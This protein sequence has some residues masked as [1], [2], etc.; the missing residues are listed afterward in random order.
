MR[1]MWPGFNSQS[2]RTISVPTIV[3]LR[4]SRSRNIHWPLDMNTSAWF[5]LHRSS[6]KTIWLVG[7]RPMVTD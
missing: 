4:L 2:P 7:A 6:F 3:P 5:R 1:T